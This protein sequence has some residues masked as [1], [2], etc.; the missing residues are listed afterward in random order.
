MCRLTKRYLAV[1]AVMLLAL[2]AA[3][4]IEVEPKERKAL[5]APEVRI[6]PKISGPEA[7]A[8]YRETVRAKIIERNFPQPIDTSRSSNK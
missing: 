8:K 1:A 6:Y 7:M 3:T 5:K 4:Q 2:A